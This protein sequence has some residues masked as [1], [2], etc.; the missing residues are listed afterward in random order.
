M[1]EVRRQVLKALCSCP[2]AQMQDIALEVKNKLDDLEQTGNKQ[3]FARTL[4]Q[5]LTKWNDKPD[6]YYSL[7]DAFQ[8]VKTIEVCFGDFR[9]ALSGYLNHEEAPPSEDTSRANSTQSV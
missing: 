4:L 7:C 8:P 1:S 5:Y 3:A 9:D 2:D 6:V